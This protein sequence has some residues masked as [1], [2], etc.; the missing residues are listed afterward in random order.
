[1]YNQTCGLTSNDNYLILKDNLLLHIII[2]KD[3]ANK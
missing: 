3:N 2:M 1:M